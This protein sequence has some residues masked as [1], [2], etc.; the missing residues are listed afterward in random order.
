MTLRRLAAAI[1]AVVTLA[2]LAT[3][4]HAEPVWRTAFVK[5]GFVGTYK[6]EWADGVGATLRNRAPLAFSGSKVRVTLRSD[7]GADS[8]LAKLTLAPMGAAPGVLAGEPIAIT[9]GGQPGVTVPMRSK[10]VTSDE[11]TGEL[12][13]GDWFVQ[14]TY[15]SPSYPYA[16]NVD[17]TYHQGG[18]QHAALK[19]TGASQSVWTGCVY[20]IDVLTTDTRPLILCYG[21][22]ITAGYNST[23]DAGHR[24]PDL[25][26]KLMDRPV[27][28]MGVNGDVITQRMFCGGEIRALNGVNIVLFLMGVNDILTGGIKSLDRYQQCAQT[29]IKQLHDGGIKVYWGTIPPFKGNKAAD[30][31]G[32]QTLDP[33]KEALRNQINTW[34][35]SSSGA[36]G[37]IDY[38][39]ALADPSDQQRLNPLYQSDWLH[40]NDAGYQVMARAAAAALKSPQ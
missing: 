18:D 32:A 40:P 38:D 1:G 15:S 7:Y 3:T 34:I 2:V 30:L 35:R 4:G 14:Q 19:L 23:P 21:D 9:F 13:A 31:A 28:N 12:K 10:D 33:D 22:S 25:L 17:S 26:A 8:V 24:Y 29:I 6:T 20:R 39:E 5:R 16:Y 27:L 37:V 11:V 36:D